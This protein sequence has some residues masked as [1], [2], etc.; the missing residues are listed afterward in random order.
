MGDQRKGEERERDEK[1]TEGGERKT[2]R[3]Q[4]EESEREYGTGREESTVCEL[5]G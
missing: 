1:R 4:R 3:G 2:R 5:Q